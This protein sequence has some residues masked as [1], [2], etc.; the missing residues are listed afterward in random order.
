MEI[1]K[2]YTNKYFLDPLKIRVLHVDFINK[3]SAKLK[4]EWYNKGMYIGEDRI[5]I[6]HKDIDNWRLV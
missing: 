4:V 1:G 5:E 2:S 6:Q 3:D